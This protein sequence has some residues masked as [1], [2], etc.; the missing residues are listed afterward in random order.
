MPG[1]DE[2]KIKLFIPFAVKHCMHMFNTFS[3]QIRW[4]VLICR[5]LR[6]ISATCAYICWK[7]PIIQHAPANF[8]GLLCCSSLE[9]KG[10]PLAT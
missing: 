5:F 3:F 4:P 2:K 8:S 1:K 10:G 6:E 9:R 7:Y